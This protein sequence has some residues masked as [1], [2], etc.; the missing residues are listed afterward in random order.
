LLPAAGSPCAVQHAQARLQAKPRW[1]TDW[2]YVLLQRNSGWAAWCRYQQW[3][4]E[5]AGTACSLP[6]ELLAMQLA[7]E[8]LLDDG[9]RAADSHWQHWHAAWDAQSAGPVTARGLIWQRAAELASHTPLLSHWRRS[10]PHDCRSRHPCRVLH[11]RALRTDAP[12]TG[13]SAAGVSTAGFAGFFGLPLAIRFAG[14]D[15]SQPRLP[16]LLAPSWEAI[17]PP[18]EKGLQEWGSFQRAPLSSF[19][20]VESAGLGKAGK[21]LRKAF[22]ASA[23][24]RWPSW[25]PG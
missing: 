12:G 2:F 3:Q 9:A 25:T 5:L 22:P 1:L 21:L 10:R 15:H 23:A 7:W 6:Q 16:G 11:R 20:L 18:L 24:P 8:C 13:T 17:M 19:T 14:E 4:A